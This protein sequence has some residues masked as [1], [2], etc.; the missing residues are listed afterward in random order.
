[1]MPVV[2]DTEG[3]YGHLSYA[4]PVAW[5]ESASGL[6]PVAEPAGLPHCA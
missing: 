3:A 5:Q 1:M 6:L 2:A 4:M